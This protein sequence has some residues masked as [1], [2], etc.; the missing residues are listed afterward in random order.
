MIQEYFGNIYKYD[1]NENKKFL[2]VI[3]DDLLL[4][5][6]EFNHRDLTLIKKKIYYKNIYMNKPNFL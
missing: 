4:I 6:K 5:K 1:I 3:L 2:F